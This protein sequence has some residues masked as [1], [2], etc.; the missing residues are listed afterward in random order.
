MSKIKEYV[1]AL[2]FAFGD[3]IA[4]EEISKRTKADPLLITKAVKE[5]N[6]IYSE[7]KSAFIISE[8]GDLLRMRLRPD[9]IPLVEENLKTDMKKGVLM[10]LSVIASKGK[11]RQSDLIKQRGSISYQHVKELTSRGLVVAYEDDNRKML[12]LSPTFFDYFDVDNKEFNDVKNE[13]K[14]S[15]KQEME[16]HAEYAPK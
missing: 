11:I 4:I 10:T 14:D 1:E 2:V 13:V 6:K 5:L 16:H 12:K 9:L 15:I 7:R 8:E 3:G